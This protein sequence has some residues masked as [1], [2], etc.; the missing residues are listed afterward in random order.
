MEPT[1][2]VGYYRN[3]GL[4]AD[5]E[6]VL[7]LLEQATS[8]GTIDWEISEWHPV[9]PSTLDEAVQARIQPISGQGVWYQSGRAYY[10]AEDGSGN[11]S[12][13]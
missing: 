8:D 12:A 2:V 1:R 3:F 4:R 9:D 7:P 11:A 10:P 13:N 6:Q 5:A